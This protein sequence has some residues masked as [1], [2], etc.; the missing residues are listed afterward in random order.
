MQQIILERLLYS[1]SDPAA[2]INNEYMFIFVNSGYCDFLNRKKQELIGSTV[3]SIITP[4]YFNDFIKPLLNRCSAGYETC[5]EAVLNDDRGCEHCYRIDFFPYYETDEML[6][7]YIS[8]AHKL[9]NLE[10]YNANTGLHIKMLDKSVNAIMLIGD[11]GMIVYANEKGWNLINNK[12]AAVISHSIK[13]LVFLFPEDIQEKI[14]NRDFDIE[15][16]YDI[17]FQKNSQFSIF[18]E[19]KISS[20]YWDGKV[21]FYFNAR[22]IS[23]RR[24]V[25]EKLIDAR[26]SE[27]V[28]LDVKERFLANISDELRNPLNGIL[29]MFQLIDINSLSDS[30][31]KIL[32]NAMHCAEKLSA[33]M[34]DLIFLSEI[35]KGVYPVLFEIDECVGYIKRF[36]KNKTGKKNLS[37]EINKE[38]DRMFFYNDKIKILQIIIHLLSNAMKFTKEGAI[39]IDFSCTE[40]LV[41]KIRDEA[42]SIPRNLKD[43]IFYPF[44]QI[45]NPY[46]KNHSGIG[47]GL[48]IVKKI[49]TLLRGEI[50]LTSGK[51]YGNEFIVII[52]SADIN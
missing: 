22:D 8:I 5:H 46:N 39:I 45:E 9:K 3:E 43:K 40:K 12:R 29:G 26:A 50:S 30:T 7:G 37:L 41:I 32:T 42:P 38:Y 10:I 27:A 34:T 33:V 25:E 6:N 18:L 35:E 21:Y 31:K 14:L 51:D 28:A 47:I 20:F 24:K 4:Q 2:V 48:S 23:Y 36:F 17:H 15:E 49:L 16:T 44:F 11:D 52:P 19:I 13:D 1:T